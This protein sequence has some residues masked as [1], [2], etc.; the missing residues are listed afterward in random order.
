MEGREGTSWLMDMLLN[1]TPEEILAAHDVTPGS[2]G[3]CYGRLRD[4]LSQIQACMRMR[5]D[6]H[7]C[8]DGDLDARDIEDINAEYLKE[9][10]KARCIYGMN[11][12]DIIIK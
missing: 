1:G 8:T 7:A 9:W 10:T 2:C 11:Q 4:L 5:G 3:A 12:V 6:L